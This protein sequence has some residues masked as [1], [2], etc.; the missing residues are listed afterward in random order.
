MGSQKAN[1]ARLKSAVEFGRGEMGEGSELHDSAL[2]A[3]LYAMMELVKNV[4]GNEVLA[5]L[6]FNVPEYYSNGTQ[7]ERVV[8]V[9][10]YLD[11]KLETL[12]PEEASAARVLREMVKNQRLG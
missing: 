7:R 6:T 10:D 12:R 4:D 11:K 1:A 5:H 8:E 9:A 3:V 2:R